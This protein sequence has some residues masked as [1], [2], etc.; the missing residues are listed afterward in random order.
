MKTGMIIVH[1]NDYESVKSLVDNVKN[2]NCID[3]IVI[4]DN[5]SDSRNKA[6]IRNLISD[7]VE[8]VENTCN[9]GFIKEISKIINES[10]STPK[11][12]Y[13]L[14]NEDEHMLEIDLKKEVL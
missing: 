3:K 5:N 9:K 1:Y 8:V 2:Y 11:K 6:G 14:Y 13:M 4:V 10:F 12:Y 7:K